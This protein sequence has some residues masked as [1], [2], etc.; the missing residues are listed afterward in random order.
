MTM[1]R[2]DGSENAFCSLY[3]VED[4]YIVRFAAAFAGHHAHVGDFGASIAGGCGAAKFRSGSDAD[5]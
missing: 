2:M 1:P 5:F 3:L 4:T